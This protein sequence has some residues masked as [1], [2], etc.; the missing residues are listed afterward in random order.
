MF[1]QFSSAIDNL[2]RAKITSARKFQI[3]VSDI[4]C[5]KFPVLYLSCESNKKP[6][7]DFNLSQDKQKAAERHEKFHPSSS[8]NKESKSFSIFAYKFADLAKRING[9]DE[10]G[11]KF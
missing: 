5:H 2:F 7:I 8:R 1:I 6:F 11:R 3:P 10:E 4:K 9:R